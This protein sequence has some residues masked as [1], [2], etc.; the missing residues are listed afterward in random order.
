M[1]RGNVYQE[2]D[3]VEALQTEEIAGAYLD[4]FEEEPLSESSSLWKT[5]NVLI[6]PH[7][8]AAS[9]QYLEMFIE[10]LA[11]RINAGDFGSKI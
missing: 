5:D 11:E 6:Q 8:S 3:L 1:G 10:E 7:L 2:S 4:V 9:P